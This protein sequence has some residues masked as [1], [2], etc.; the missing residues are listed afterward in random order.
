MTNGWTG[1]QYSLFRAVFGVYL[2]IHFVH[3]LPW[4]AE[5]FSR[6]GMLPDAR[7]SPLYPLFPN[8]LFVWDTPAVVTLLLAV[9]ALASVA[10]TLGFRDRAAAVLVWWVWAC[11][12]T[13]N[14]LIANPGLP[15]VGWLLLMHAC[16]PPGA[17]GTWT[18]RGA[19]DPG[20][21]WRL[22]DAL[23]AAAWIVMAVG[24]SYSGWMKL[25]SV[26]WMDGSALGRV[27]ENPLAR[28]TMLR[29]L[30]LSMPAWLTAV[31]TWGA[32]A[33]EL[34]FAPLA[35]LRVLRPWLWLAMLGMHASLLTLLDFADLTLGMVMLQLVTFDPAWVRPVREREPALL[36]YDGAC[37]LC[38][39]TIRFLL[40][41]D[42][43]GEAFRFAPLDSEAFR[44]AVSPA[45]R[46]GL[47]D[48]FVLR[49]ASGAL[50]TRSASF[51]EM[52][53]RLGG[54]WRVLAELLAWV[55]SALRDAV[56]ERVARV[57]RRLFSPP[58]DACPL[59]PP[60]LRARFILD[61]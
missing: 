25:D 55:P 7:S 52:G 53:R 46:D 44:A 14:P 35:L 24:Y 47:P 39:R 2:T 6:D 45:E 10:L 19:V 13:R 42:R 15:Y 27:L 4:G 41:E 1:G 12:F 17:Y 23:F 49:T 29:E 38:H 16:V 3:L 20:S 54:V 43:E 34:L 56:Y 11:L 18:A 30:A 21:R 31:A 59:L 48:S 37:G 61:A 33:L 58:D 5:L 9:G 40:S 50:V 26:S 8:L 28:P 22:P 51:I 57:R 32:L 36:F 60:E